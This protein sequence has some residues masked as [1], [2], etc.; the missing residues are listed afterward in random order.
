MRA[1]EIRKWWL[2]PQNIGFDHEEY[3]E[4][5][6][7]TSHGSTIKLGI[8]FSP[9]VLIRDQLT[10]SESLMIEIVNCSWLKFPLYQPRGYPMKSPSNTTSL[11]GWIM[12]NHHFP[13]L[14]HNFPMLNHHVP[15]SNHHLP[16]EF[17]RNF[18]GRRRTCH[19]LSAAAGGIGV[20][21]LHQQFRISIS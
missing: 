7:N 18:Q 13:S 11:T 15:R 12:V 14:N 4:R 10:N 9:D 2:S 19:E 17:P 8:Q 5:V 3:E 1:L 6:M 20:P 16:T 21:L